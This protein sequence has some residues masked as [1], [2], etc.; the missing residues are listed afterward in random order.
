MMNQAGYQ[1]LATNRT[2]EAIEV[3]KRN[4][5]LYPNSANCLDNL[6]LAFEKSG[7][8][9][10]AVETYEKALKM[11]EKHGETQLA[12]SAKANFERLSVKEK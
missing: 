3:F 6:A 5:E 7:Q 10:K 12:A 9:K 11:A 4:A 2:S 1:L 8:K